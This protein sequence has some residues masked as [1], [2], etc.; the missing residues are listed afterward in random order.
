[1]RLD[2][3]IASATVLSRR[4]VHRLI[5]AGDVLV[6]GHPAR[7][8]TAVG[9][10][11]EVT[12]YEKEVVPARHVYLALHKPAGYICATNDADHPIVLDLVAGSK[13]AHHPTEALQVVGRLD[14]DTTGLVLIT[15]DGQWNHKVTSP[16]GKCRKTYQVTLAQP[17]S[18]DDAHKLEQGV[19]LRSETKPTRPCTIEVNSPTQVTIELQEGKYHQVKR[20]L[21]AV[22]NR[23]T[24]LHRSSI[25]SVALGDIEPGGFRVLTQ[26]EV[27]SIA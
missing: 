5:K 3:Y 9:V 20:M 22:G 10:D 1:M 17:L 2:R 6:N 4:E 11:D 21:A 12:L 8:N 15:T 27:D 13:Q 7:N 14:I 23:V 16:N 18:A 26:E 19:L 25:G 24:Q